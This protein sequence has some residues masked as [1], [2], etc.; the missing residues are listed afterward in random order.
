MGEQAIPSTSTLIQ[1]QLGL[2]SSGITCFDINSTC[3]SF[4]TALD[5][6]AY[7]IESGRFKR[8]LIV[9]SD[10]PS[11]GLNWQDMETCTIFGDGAAACI[12]EKSDG[13][14]SILSTHME[15]HSVGSTYCRLEAGGTR[16]LPSH[17]DHQRY[18][19]FYMEGKKVFKLASRLVA[20]TKDIVFN[21]ARLTMDA[22]DWVIPHQASKLA[23]HHVRKNLRIPHEKFVD[24]YAT[25]GNQMAASIPTVLY[26]LIESKKLQR[27]HLIYFLGTGAGISSGGMIMEY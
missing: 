23:M 13:T 14:S 22:I 8:A 12:I 6:M 10:I 27:G 15:T 1:K 11:F 9:S 24:I 4:L 20:N 16:I 5:T 2:E 3:L 17:P 18:A 7:L 25:H 26:S 21:K 19:L